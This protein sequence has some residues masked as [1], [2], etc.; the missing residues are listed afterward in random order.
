M[1]A[2]TGAG[3]TSGAGAAE[4]T[5]AGW[6][7]VTGPPPGS[8][9]FKTMAKSEGS[10][11]TAMLYTLH[12]KGM[13]GCPAKGARSMVMVSKPR[14]FLAAQHKQSGKAQELRRRCCADCC[15][16][17]GAA[18]CDVVGHS[19]PAR[20]PPRWYGVL[21]GCLEL[22]TPLRC[23]ASAPEVKV[24]APG[25]GGGLAEAPALQYRSRSALL[26]LDHRNRLMAWAPGG[27]TMSPMTTLVA[28]K[29]TQNST[30]WHQGGCRAKASRVFDWQG[31]RRGSD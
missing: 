15:Y 2:S 20:C 31:G 18:A 12:T 26:P 24:A 27:A 8:T 14:P 22:R 4:G 30:Q 5:A 17:A 9:G 11:V 7:G 10:P 19:L 21:C 29:G 23:T 28:C 3:A 1:G 13:V 6:T 25:V 16:S